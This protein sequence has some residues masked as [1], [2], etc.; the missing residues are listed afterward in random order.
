MLLA[1]LVLLRI[2]GLLASQTRTDRY[3]DSEGRDAM[4]VGLLWR[5]KY[6]K[7]ANGEAI[8]IFNKPANVTIDQCTFDA[9]INP[10]DRGGVIYWQSI[11]LNLTQ[12]V[13]IN[14]QAA[15]NT[16]N[17]SYGGILV[18][19]KGP[20]DAWID[21]C[22]F[23]DCQAW[24]PGGIIYLR[25]DPGSFNNLAITNCDF[26][27][28]KV[29]NH[30]TQKRFDA[31]IMCRWLES[32]TFT[33]NKFWW[34]PEE[35]APVR[36]SALLRLS[37]ANE[38]MDLV[39]EGLSVANTSFPEGLIV[40]ENETKSI[41]YRDFKF[42]T[43]RLGNESFQA[44]ILP[45]TGTAA[46]NLIECQFLDC[47]TRDGFVDASGAGIQTVNLDK[48]RFSEC[49]CNKSNGFLVFK[50]HTNVDVKECYFGNI[51][52]FDAEEEN[53][54]PY[55]LVSAEGC[56]NVFIS[57]TG[58]DLPKLSFSNLDL[59]FV[60]GNLD[61]RQC[62]FAVDG[63]VDASQ[64]LLMNYRTVKINNCVFQ[65]DNSTCMKPVLQSS[66]V[67]SSS[68]LL[69]FNCCFTHESDLDEP[70][71]GALYLKLEG[72]GKARFDSACF[73]TTKDRSMEYNT[74][75]KL[76]IADDQESIMFGNCTCSIFIPLPTP[77][78]L[79]EEEPDVPIPTREESSTT[80]NTGIITGIIF[81]LLILI[82]ILV[83]LIL[84]LLFR[85]R[86]KE[87]S[88]TEGM[89]P[90]EEPEETITSLHEGIDADGM[91]GATNDN[92]LFAAELSTND[93]FNNEFEE[94]SF[95]VKDN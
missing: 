82:I 45:E 65:I 13:F 66:G 20:G 33:N 50:G 68:D 89:P 70:P 41:T 38:N 86:R 93:I 22:S 4:F 84:F 36:S 56:E 8:D 30:L 15:G 47:W 6:G 24:N 69:F 34:V 54:V 32:F 39:I 46:L 91:D 92:P 88:T 5:G 26:K 42:E 16:N 2:E 78:P 23:E 72:H 60:G 40:L 75:I 12:S 28:C 76:E 58:F 14:C 77:E 27:A 73:D 18:S 7:L 35:A 59:S 29:G 48:C 81:G 53:S 94:T 10:M 87:K 63:R 37:F 61:F 85:R 44:G 31:Q 74:N 52:W 9:V 3:E 90:P 49:R 57:E 25:Y 11:I 21:D 43:V 67:D 19:F 62:T 51:R 1:G 71:E 80:I 79:T 55:H 95:F 83:L 17:P 64:F